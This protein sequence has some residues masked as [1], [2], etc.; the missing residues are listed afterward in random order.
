MSHSNQSL[1]DKDKDY[2]PTIKALVS[3]MSGVY[4]LKSVMNFKVNALPQFHFTSW[5]RI[6]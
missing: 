2:F 3:E 4:C 5:K 6:I 1:K